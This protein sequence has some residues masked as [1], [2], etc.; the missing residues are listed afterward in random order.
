MK[1]PACLLI[2]LICLICLSGLSC[3]GQDTIM[4][5]W[6]GPIP[7]KID[8]DEQEIRGQGDILWIRKVQ[9]PTLEVYLPTRRNRTG[10]GVVVCPGGGYSGLAYDWEGTD[11]AKWLNAKGIAAFVLKYRLPESKSLVNR[12]EVPLLDAKRAIQKV[13]A[14]T[15]QWGLSAAKIGVM[16]FSAGGHLASS[17][18][19]HYDSAGPGLDSLDATSAR[20]DFCILVYPVITMDTTFG[21]RGSRNSLLGDN[22]SA[23]LV[24][25]FSNELHVNNQTP[26][27][28]LLHSSDDKGVPV[29]NSIRFYQALQRH[30]V[31][32]EM[33]IYPTGGHGYALAMGDDYLEN[34]PDL[35]FA[36]LK[37]LNEPD[38]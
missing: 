21:H 11:V 27:T 34:W 32:A 35:L 4:P 23:D 36:W 20:P 2:T 26:P 38:R 14:H 16:G 5:L 33:H 25:Y 28:F 7:N 13:R 19:V 31:S 15:G 24:N 17:L 22:P 3:W 10:Q 30:K 18:A 37:R 29:E 8:S 9:E 12:H 1:K 6:D